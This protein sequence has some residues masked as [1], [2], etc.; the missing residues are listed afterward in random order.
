MVQNNVEKEWFRFS[1]CNAEV[2]LEGPC[3]IGFP[4]PVLWNKVVKFRG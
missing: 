1:R 4:Q 3:E 2:G